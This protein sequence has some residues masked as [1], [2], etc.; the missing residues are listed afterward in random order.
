MRDF[1]QIFWLTNKLSSIYIDILMNEPAEISLVRIFKALADVSRLRLV[2]V[3]LHGPYSVAE[4]QQILD[5][6]QSRVSRH[7]KLLS[8]AGLARVRREGTWAY[9][10]AVGEKS[11]RAVSQQIEL[12]REVAGGLPNAS[13]DEARRLVCLEK[14]RQISQAFHERVASKWSRLREDLFGDGLVIERTIEQIENAAVVADLGCGAGELL[15]L[16]ATRADKV[17]GVDS[18][19]GML[20]QAR[21]AVLRVDAD[22]EIELRLGSLEHL[23]LADGEVDAALINMVLHHLADPPAVLREVRRILK[24]SGRLVICD[25]ARHDQ[26][27]MREKYGD[28]WLGFTDQELKRFLEQAGMATLS[29]EHYQAPRAG[30]VVAVAQA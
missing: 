19:T 28:Q 10:E 23:P 22:C 4:L 1:R 21:L 25:F 18:S 11:E 27:W 7:L 5:M 26:E 15:G 2:S 12:I 6:G 9:Y 30:L 20:E 24:K 3:L 29:M 17:I 8:E 16:L 14:R 13:E